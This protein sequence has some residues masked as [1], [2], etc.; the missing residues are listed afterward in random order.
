MRKI[1][2]KPFKM[3]RKF[4]PPEGSI[5]RYVMPIEAAVLAQES[6]EKHDRR[7]TWQRMQAWFRGEPVQSEAW[8]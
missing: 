1:K 3:P 4:K 6:Y 8:L 2:P 7:Q 5:I